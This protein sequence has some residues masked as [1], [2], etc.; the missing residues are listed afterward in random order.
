[1][2]APKCSGRSFDDAGIK[3]PSVILAS[4]KS[5]SAA[6]SR[7]SWSRTVARFV[8]DGS[9][10]WTNPYPHH[11]TD[12]S[13]AM[14]IHT[15]R[16]SSGAAIIRACRW[17]DSLGWEEQLIGAVEQNCLVW[18]KEFVG[19]RSRRRRTATN[20]AVPRVKPYHI[21]VSVDA[22]DV[23]YDIPGRSHVQ[24]HQLCWRQCP[25]TSTISESATSISVDSTNEMIVASAQSV[26]GY[27]LRNIEYHCKQVEGLQE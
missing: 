2:P 6:V 4:I 8:A 15:R 14:G 9:A 12:D 7:S 17:R 16:N 10:G 18:E 3:R 20:S 26:S 1:M 22:P 13:R 27:A 5:A 21:H 24:E 11:R 19:D 25:F 23:R